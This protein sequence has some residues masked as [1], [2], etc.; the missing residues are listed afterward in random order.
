MSQAT[1]TSTSGN[2]NFGADATSNLWL[3]GGLLLAG[4]VIVWL[5]I[6]KG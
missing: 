1:S 6:R 4:V 5:T 2:V 3:I